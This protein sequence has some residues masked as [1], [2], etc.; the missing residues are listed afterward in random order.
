MA[1]CCVQNLNHVNQTQNTNPMR[2][3]TTMIIMVLIINTTWSQENTLRI[4]C[5]VLDAKTKEP[6]ANAT[7]KVKTA[8]IELIS[9]D[10]NF[11][12]SIP[13][14]AVNDSLEVSY[15]GY[16]TFKKRIAE[17]K[18]HENVFLEDY[19]IELKAVTVTSRMLNLKEIDKGLRP[20]KGI[21]YAYETETTNGLYNLFLN[22]LEEHGQTELLKQCEYDLSAYD[23]KTK[24]Y[25]EEYT[26]PYVKP[27]NKKD[28]TVKN[29]TD[30]PAVNVAHGAAVL[31]CQWLTEQYNSNTGKKKFSKV[32]FR[33]PTLKEWQIAA[34]GYV[35]F[36]SWNLEENMLEVII[37]D[38]TLSEKPVKGIRKT[39]PVAQDVLYPW[40][41][42]YYYR[43]KPQN[44]LGCFLGNFKVTY[45]EKPCSFTR[46]AF[47]GWTMMARTASY[48]P[49]NM[50][51]YDVVGNVAEM[52][53]EKGKAC[54]GSWNDLP[55][56]STL[57]SIKSYR[58]PDSSIGF[59]IF[60]DVIEK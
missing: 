27:L 43:R 33:L 54:G 18:D 10:G 20:I 22:Y 3:C 28:T 6:L 38:D 2:V 19:S 29:H 23:A 32:K 5:K 51:L 1:K 11:V 24:A 53:D 45:V 16:K 42:A 56:A 21:L 30:F 26:K 36:Q 9:V 40:Y 34:L 37:P 14:D 50:G 44:H 58:K 17:I 15:I 8:E 52:I 49:N 57:H 59:R 47:D 46:V 12:F 35:K 60:M 25:Y 7:V 39:I 41:G 55:S 4:S 48:F 13:A 31:F